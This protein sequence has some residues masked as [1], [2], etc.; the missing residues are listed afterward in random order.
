MD[1]G[2]I[3]E[4]NGKGLLGLKGIKAEVGQRG[5]GKKVC[6]KIPLTTCYSISEL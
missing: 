6:M 3:I 2:E 4:Q 5:E 1:V